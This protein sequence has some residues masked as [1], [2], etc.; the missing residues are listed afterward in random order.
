[1]TPELIKAACLWVVIP[2]CLTT[3]VVTVVKTLGQIDQLLHAHTTELL[4]DSRP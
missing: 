4:H 3:I 1:M 2:I